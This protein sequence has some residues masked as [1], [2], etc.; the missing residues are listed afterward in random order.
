MRTAFSTA[1]QFSDNS[2]VYPNTV[3]FAAAAWIGCGSWGVEIFPCPW[4]LL[5]PN[6]C[7]KWREFGR[8]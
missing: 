2:R 8:G 5:L 4:W 3:K 1:V 7:I 6:I